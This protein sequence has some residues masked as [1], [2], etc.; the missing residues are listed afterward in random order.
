MPLY[1]FTID[2]SDHGYSDGCGTVLSHNEAAR[3]YAHR[4]MREL[5]EGEHPTLGATMDV[6][7]EAGHTV[8]SIPFN[9]ISNR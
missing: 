5:M 9:L 2:A 1:Y 3:E 7:D 4:V 6:K 8:Y